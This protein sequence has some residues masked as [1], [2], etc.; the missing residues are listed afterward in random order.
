[1]GHATKG[2]MIAFALVVAG[3]G[4][5]PVY[6]TPTYQ[7][8]SGLSVET[9]PERIDFLVQNAISDFAGPGDSP[10]TLKVAIEVKE[11]GAGLS[12][13]GVATRM[14]LE[15]DAEYTLVGASEDI[16]GRVSQSVTYDTEN[17]PYALLAARG[18]GE[19]RLAQ[20]LAEYIMLDVSIAL[21]DA[22]SS[23]ED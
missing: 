8:L 12:A 5:Q 20:L 13:S 2:L 18:Q 9:G 17:S 10:Y 15:G 23:R 7:A 19:K 22:S 3:C 14:T 21:R 16:S 11:Q 4:F 1:M 6:H